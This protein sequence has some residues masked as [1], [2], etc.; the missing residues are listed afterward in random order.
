M[1]SVRTARLNNKDGPASKES[2]LKH[3]QQVKA[4]QADKRTADYPK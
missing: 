4:Q 3:S 1:A 2:T